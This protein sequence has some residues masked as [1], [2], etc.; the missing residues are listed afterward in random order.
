MNEDTLMII[1][2]I[3]ASNFLCSMAIVDN[4]RKELKEIKENMQSSSSKGSEIE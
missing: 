2:F 4:L 3:L 1:I